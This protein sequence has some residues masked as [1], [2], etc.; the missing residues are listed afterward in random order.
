MACPI[1]TAP[2]GAAIA[3]GVRAG[4]IAMIAVAGFIVTAMMRF[5]WR[6]WRLRN[7]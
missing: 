5:A 3:D 1:C 6:L 4:A 7:A 2:E